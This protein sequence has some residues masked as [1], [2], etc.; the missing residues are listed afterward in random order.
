MPG[1]P[2][3]QII[4]SS[5][6]LGIFL[7]MIANGVL[8]FPSSQVLYIICGFFIFT[9]D[10]I[11]MP[12][13]FIGALGNTIGNIIIYE[14][15]RRK[16]LKYIAKWGVFPEKIISKVQNVFI[17]KGIWFVFIGK[18]TPALKVFV[19]ISAGIAKMNRISYGV[20][21]AVASTIWTLPF[22]AIGY[23]FGKSSDVFSKY[24][25]I[26]LGFAV[27]VAWVFYK[28]TCDEKI[29]DGTPDIKNEL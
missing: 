9:G 19:P 26:L 13:I 8:G 24:A 28:Y 11:L 23:Y 7:L 20:A 22:L 10:L 27:L 14:L 3:E 21:V 17:K 25:L 16:G 15:V 18:L 2:I 12:V 5:S 4:I 6:Y 1:I 29:E